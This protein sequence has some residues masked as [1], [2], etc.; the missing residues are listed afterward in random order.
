MSAVLVAAFLAQIAGGPNAVIARWGLVPLALSAGRWEGLFGHIL[1]HGGWLHLFLNTTALLAFGAP[2]ARFYGSSLTGALRF[3][4][5]FTLCGVAGGLAFWA[6]HPMGGTPLVGASGA[7]SGL[8]GG[9]GRLSERQGR[10]SGPFSRAAI[11]FVTPWIV[12]NLLLALAGTAFALPIAWEAHLGGLL[13]GLLLVG[14][15]ARPERA[16]G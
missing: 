5:F 14:L 12:L 10:L 16:A 2:V 13:A 3:L 6:L 1:L 11:G 9:A 7:I 8:M 4:L 15:F